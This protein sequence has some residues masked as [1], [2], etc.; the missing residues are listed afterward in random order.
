MSAS[1]PPVA[2]MADGMDLVRGGS[3]L[4]RR[5]SV[6]SFTSNKK[7]KLSEP[8]KAQVKKTIKQ[9]LSNHIQQKVHF[10]YATHSVDVAGAVDHLTAIAQGVGERQRIG[11]AIRPTRLKM[12]IHSGIGDNTNMLRFIIFRWHPS[13]AAGVPTLASVTEDVAPT[14]LL[15][16]TG[17]PLI[18]LNWPD[19]SQFTV[20]YDRSFVL[21]ANA[22]QQVLLN[23]E[24][25]GK[26]VNPR[27][28][29]V[30]TSTSAVLNGL[31]IA[32]VSDS[33]AVAHP[34]LTYTLQ[35]EFEDA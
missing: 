10:H 15:G 20:L 18:P 21:D 25:F 5:A 32:F 3:S 14:N 24:L 7:A 27:I 11:N 13:A 31:Y 16:T 30:D 2:I 33:G 4:K 1:V 28:H 34:T 6:K 35:L 12:R 9:I 26:K 8:Q 17:A 19:K 23:L 29:Y 22:P